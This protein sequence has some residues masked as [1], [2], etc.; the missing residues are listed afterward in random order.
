[1]QAS[2]CRCV[3]STLPTTRRRSGHSADD[4][5]IPEL[6]YSSDVEDGD[7]G[8]ISKGWWRTDNVLTQRRLI[9]VVEQD[10]Q[11]V[12]VS[13]MDAGPADGRGSACSRAW[14]IGK[15]GKVAYLIVSAIAPV[16]TEPAS[17]NFEVRQQ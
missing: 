2:R 14:C 6:N 8:W 7:G 17:Y 9:Q 1:M 11:G 15:D 3:S 5:S 13:V 10:R 4:I 12:K 16:T